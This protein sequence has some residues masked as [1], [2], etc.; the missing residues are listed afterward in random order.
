MEKVRINIRKRVFAGLLAVLMIMSMAGCGNTAKSKNE[1]SVDE[2]ECVFM[3]N[4]DFSVDSSINIRKVIKVGEDIAFISYDSPGGKIYYKPV[5]GGEEKVIYTSQKGIGVDNITEVDGNIG[6]IEDQ[7]L[8]RT[9][10]VIDKDGNEVSSVSLSGLDDI[11]IDINSSS[12][13]VT[14]D[15]EVAVSTNQELILLNKEGRETKRIQF[16]A[17]IMSSCLTKNGEIAVFGAE[18]QEKVEVTFIDP[19]TGKKRTTAQIS[20]EYLD[21]GAVRTGFGDYDFFVKKESGL[22][23]YKTDD[24]TD[25]MICDFNTSVIDGT[26]VKSCLFLDMEHFICQSYDSSSQKFNMSSYSKVDPSE[27]GDV[28]TLTVGSIVSSYELQQDITDFNKTHPGVRISLI[29]Y[30]EEEDPVA[31]FSADIG[32]G[33][34]ADIYDVSFGY[35]DI[36]VNQAVQKGLIED[37][38]PYLE[39]DPDISEDDF[40]DSIMRASKIDGKI[41]YLGTSFLINALLVKKSEIGDRTGWTYDE[42]MEYIYSKP[43]DVYPFEK[44]GKQEIL[45]GFLYAGMSEFVDWEK[46][47]CNFD[48]ESFKALLEYSNRGTDDEV[49]EWDP[50]MNFVDD[51][52]NGKQLFYNGEI[53]PTIWPLYEKFFD[54]DAAWIGYPDE[55][56]E[57]YYA[58]IYGGLGIS[59]TCSDK[60]TAWEFIKFCA[61]KEQEGKSYPDAMGIPTRKDVFEVFME[62]KMASEPYID[63][64]GNSVGLVD[65][66][67]GLGN[68]TVDLRALTEEEAQEFRDLTDKVSNVYTEDNKIKDIITDECKLYYSGE[69]SLDDTVKIIQNRAQT[70][71]NESR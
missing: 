23:G 57:G 64:F 13:S 35:G 54:G 14:Q 1:A 58:M 61:S 21:D 8:K 71:M 46:G 10:K 39:K 48:S 5:T 41:Y 52:Q 2:K 66:C 22:Y 24:K 55:N 28:K 27:V 30:S 9:L 59:S 40:L 34:V 11:S 26:N 3:E 25:H 60:D 6:I 69:K 15:G 70:Y 36:T 68:V 56:R 65:G 7:D 51:L 38:T 62:S 37:L 32:A 4:T 49:T 44:K 29:D 19:K 17:G 43:D 47:E 20:A 16:P 53:E 18:N 45:S 31:K 67:F 42:M 63:E 50:E 12:Y 33:I